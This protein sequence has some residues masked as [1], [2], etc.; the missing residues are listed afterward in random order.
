M[1][2]NMRN[3]ILLLLTYLL[4]RVILDEE[5]VPHELAAQHPVDAPLDAK[6][7]FG[8]LLILAASR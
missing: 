8:T 5:A 1:F 3:S 2:C 7:N 4:R 6:T